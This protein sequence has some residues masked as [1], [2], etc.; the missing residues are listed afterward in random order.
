MTHDKPLSDRAF[1]G[2]NPNIDPLTGHYTPGMESRRTYG[3]P[4]GA[5]KK[6]EPKPDPY[7]QWYCAY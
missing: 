6:V 7:D 5:P 4:K 2:S 3:Q 1:G